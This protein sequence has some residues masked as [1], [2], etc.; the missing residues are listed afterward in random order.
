MLRNDV[1]EAEA[2]AVEAEK[3]LAEANEKIDDQER[4]MTSLHNKV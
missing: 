4:T 2:R 1:E 3:Q